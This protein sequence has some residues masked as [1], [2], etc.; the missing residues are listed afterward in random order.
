M[1]NQIV[2]IKLYK[3]V[4]LVYFLLL[5]LVLSACRSRRCNVSIEISNYFWKDKVYV[6][7]ACLEDNMYNQYSGCTREEYWSEDSKLRVKLHGKSFVFDVANPVKQRMSENDSIWNFWKNDDYMII[8]AELPE[9]IPWKLIVPL[10]YY[11][12][13]N[14]WSERDKFFYISEKGIIQLD[15]ELEYG[16]KPKRISDE[17][18]EILKR[19]EGWL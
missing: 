18:M 15:K 14:S 3:R 2:M 5:I 16:N 4:L 8:I 19:S 6:D 1:K 11:S 10:D 7:V 17:D 9:G 13:F 12:F